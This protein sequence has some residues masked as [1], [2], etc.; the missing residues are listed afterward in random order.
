[1]PRS[2]TWHPERCAGMS[3]KKLEKGLA[4]NGYACDGAEVT[5]MEHRLLVA[6]LRTNTP[7]H[8]RMQ[9]RRI[10]V[11]YE[12]DDRKSNCGLAGSGSS[13]TVPHQDPQQPSCSS[14]FAPAPQHIDGSSTPPWDPPAVSPGLS[15]VWAE[16]AG[17]VHDGCCFWEP[18]LP[19]PGPMGGSHV[20]L[21]NLG[22]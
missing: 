9:H 8:V 6:V 5:A 11:A 1:M 21:R 17:R 7:H 13:G 10:T 19:V 2:A 4:A 20:Q 15:A 18:T 12:A 16:G 14:Q 3:S 22:T